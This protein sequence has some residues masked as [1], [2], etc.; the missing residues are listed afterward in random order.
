MPEKF[1]R[2]AAE[3]VQYGAGIIAFY[4]E[5]NVIDTL[6]GY[7]YPYSDAVN[8]TNDGCWEVLIPGKTRFSYCPMDML[9]YLQTDVLAVNRPVEND[10]SFMGL[11]LSLIT[12]SPAQKDDPIPEYASFEDLYKALLKSIEGGISW[13]H[14][15]LD[16]Q[17]F[18][19]SEEAPATA[20]VLSL[21]VEGCIEKGTD[22][23][24]G[25]AYYDVQSIHMGGVQ[26]C[27]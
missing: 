9:H 23:S 24:K 3:V 16:S 22:F 5:Q 20:L 15:L 13:L 19:R 1:L 8:F 4:D 7:G 14:G 26:D 17:A 6:T 21:F 10:G 12:A 27:S 18:Y 2:R 11:Y 25:G